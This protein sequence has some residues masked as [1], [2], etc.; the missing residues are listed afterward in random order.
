MYLPFS[1][2]SL[3]I[4]EECKVLIAMTITITVF[5]AETRYRPVETYRYL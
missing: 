1:V 4:T 3:S 5:Y 2:Q